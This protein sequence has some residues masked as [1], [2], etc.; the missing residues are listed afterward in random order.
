[1]MELHDQ[2]ESL[3]PHCLRRIPARKIKTND[4]VYLEKSCPQHGD[5]EKVLLW[6]DN[7][8]PF[9]LW[10]RMPAGETALSHAGDLP[11]APAHNECPYE[12]GLC[13][14]HQQATCSVIIEVTQ[15]CD[16][17][18]PICFASSGTGP[19]AHPD[20]TQIE[21]MLQAIRDSSGFC[22]VQLSGGEPALRDDLPQIVALARK[23]G[24]DHI[25]INTNGI[26]LAQDTDFGTALK[27]AG[28]TDFFLQFDGLTKDVYHHIRG[29]D[30]LSFKFKAVERCA[31]LK[32]G[33]VLVPTLVKHINDTQVGAIIR[34]A[35][36]WIP[37]VRGVH[38]QP[39]TYIGRYPNSPSNE[40][41]ILIP[42]ILA[43]IEEQTDE[44]LKAEDFV[45][46][47]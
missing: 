28:T 2:T 4:A 43:A 3:C 37:T 38:F 40:N 21:R 7:P 42:D 17:R 16:I 12:C 35:K 26:R 30:L 15:Q 5:L 18:C 33:V 47:G 9:N 36:R 22:P 44:E 29:A 27:D 8:V 19:D 32:I 25:Q 10:N 23:I 39:I 31:E 6:R 13:P 46:P 34:Y 45:P 14:S 41:R 1:M 11:I 24:F 20:L